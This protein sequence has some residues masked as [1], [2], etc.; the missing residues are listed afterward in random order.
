[1]WAYLAG[2]LGVS[3]LVVFTVSVI[4]FGLLRLSGDLA[5]SLAGEGATV[6]Q[7]AEIKRLY[8]LDRPLAIQYLDWASHAVRGDLGNS[9]VSNQ[10]VFG[11]IT[12]HLQVT[13]L[14]AV[15]SLT[16]AVCVAVPLGVFSAVYRD[17]WIDHLSRALAV[18]GSAVPNFW[19]ALML[20]YVFGVQLRW[21]PISGSQTWASFILPTVTLS[22]MVMPQIM[23]LTRS[24]MIDALGAEYVKMAWAKGL[25]PLVVFF[26]HA[27]PNAILP[28]VTLSAVSL[29]FLLGGS[30][31]VES[32]F[33]V[34]GIGL[35]AYESIRRADFPVVQSILFVLSFVY[36]VLTFLS[37]LINAAI[38]PR[39]RLH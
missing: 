24:G 16:A 26:K 32:V 14:L 36:V 2:R 1:M 7:V 4:S 11:M 27:L 10:P 37:D 33:S 12:S 38:D 8:G 25:N 18:F 29:G 9:L 20:I 17:G 13:A 28:V 31:I 5:Q 15:L 21:L 35:L 6:E 19:F 30:V 23:R 34:N 3:L 22:T 39:L